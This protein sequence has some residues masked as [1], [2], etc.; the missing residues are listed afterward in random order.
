M[1]T[2]YRRELM[3]ALIFLCLFSASCWADTRDYRTARVNG[4]G[5]SSP[6]PTG[7]VRQSPF[8]DLFGNPVYRYTT[9]AGTS[10][11]RQKPFPDLMGNP[12]YEVRD[13]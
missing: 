10:V 4:M 11:I 7:S 8:P 3:F 2:K 13:E 6:L 1:K 9:S 5:P 12:V